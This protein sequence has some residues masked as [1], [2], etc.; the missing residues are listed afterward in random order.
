MGHRIAFFISSHG[1]GH[2]ARACGIMAAAQAVLPDTHFDIFTAAPAWFFKESLRGPF[3][4]HHL[5]TDIGLVQRTPFEEDL[6]ETIRRLDGFFPFS[7]QQIQQAAET[8]SQRDCNLI[9][10]DISPMGIAVGRAAGIPSVLVENFTWDWIYS[11]YANKHPGIRRH[12]EYLKELFSCADT[13][14][15]TDPVC[16]PRKTDFRFP[17]ISR[18]ARVLPERT[19]HRLRIPRDTPM[20]MVTMGG[21]PQ[22]YGVMD[23]FFESPEYHFVFTGCGDTVNRRNNLTTLPYTSEFYHPDLIRAADVVVG[24]AGYSTMAEAYD[25]GCPYLFVT[26]PMFGESDI[27]SAFVREHM[28]GKDIA[29]PEFEQGGWVSDLMGLLER[30]RLH[31]TAKPGAQQAAELVCG[32]LDQ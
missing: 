31:H 8:L 16:N 5:L 32:L 29:E 22:D 21:V 3:T 15:Q 25:A 6:P 26:R 9:L 20:V 4:Y 13:H 17:P 12:M 28:V 23:R 18:P 19:R 7:D 24:K 30:P 10:C 1:L 27:L 11:A 2:A 14:V